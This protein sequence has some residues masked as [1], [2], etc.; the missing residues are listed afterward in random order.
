MIFDSDVSLRTDGKG[1]GWR[2]HYLVTP[3]LMHYMKCD[4]KYVSDP[5]I[6][7]GLRV[8]GWPFPSTPRRL[9]DLAAPTRVDF[10]LHSLNT[11]LTRHQTHC[12]P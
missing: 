7:S 12:N 10:G 11:R 9:A 4:L 5:A 2:V 8:G 6:R 3:F 1:M